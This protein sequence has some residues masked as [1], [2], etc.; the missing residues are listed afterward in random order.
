MNIGTAATAASNNDMEASGS[1]T[2]H[3]DR[4]PSTSGD[5]PLSELVISVEQVCKNDNNNAKEAGNVN[6]WPLRLTGKNNQKTC[7]GGTDSTFVSFFT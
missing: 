2:L 5:L 6:N 4:D 7:E 1:V 3:W